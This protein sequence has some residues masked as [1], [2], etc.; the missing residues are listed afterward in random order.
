MNKKMIRLKTLIDEDFT[1]Y[2]KPAMLLAFPTCDF[3]CERDA[4]AKMC[5]NTPLTLSPT[6]DVSITNIIERYATNAI[7]SAIVC[8]GLEPMDSYEELFNLIRAFRESGFIEDDIVIYT[9][10]NLEEV[11]VKVKKL[12]IFKNIIIKFGRY[13]PHE[14]AVYDE[15]LGVK[16]ASSNQYGKIIS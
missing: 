2:K 4:C 10:Y 7:T 1:N 11:E 14:Q 16:L 8:G 13:I 6:I 12:S 5:Q 3:K 9:G 15:V